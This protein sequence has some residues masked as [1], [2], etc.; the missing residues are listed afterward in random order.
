MTDTNKSQEARRVLII[1]DDV[2]VA[3]L[4][5]MGLQFEGLNCRR[6]TDGASGLRAFKEEPPHL[7][8]LDI[9]MPGMS[10][11]EVLSEI[12]GMSQVPVIIVSALARD[13]EWPTANGFIAKPFSPM[14]L[15]KLVK[16]KLSEYY[17]T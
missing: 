9:M 3:K 4:M 5:E 1:E 17:E 15:A 2:E 6:E 13:E 10:G 7:V 8:L 11:R 16:E 14:R 12:R